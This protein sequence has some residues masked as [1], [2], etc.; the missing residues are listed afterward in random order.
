MLS[1]L[2]KKIFIVDFG[3]FRIRK[4]NGTYKSNIVRKDILQTMQIDDN[5]LR[6]FVWKIILPRMF[7]NCFIEMKCPKRGARPQPRDSLVL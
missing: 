7:W 6:Q 4:E 3:L 1:D 2:S 5:L